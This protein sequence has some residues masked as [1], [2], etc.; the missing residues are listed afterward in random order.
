MGLAFIHR[1][2][3]VNNYLLL[4]F[5]FKYLLITLSGLLRFDTKQD[6]QKY[7]GVILD[8]SY[9]KAPEDCDKK[10]ES[11]LVSNLVFRVKMLNN[12]GA[13]EMKVYKVVR[14]NYVQD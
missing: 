10:I 5:S 2:N 1:D 7:A 14:A 6:Q 4:L 11:N 12:M 13:Y 3:K 9:F 8:F